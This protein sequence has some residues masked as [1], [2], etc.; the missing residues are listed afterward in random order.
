LVGAVNELPIQGTPDEP[1]SGSRVEHKR[2]VVIGDVGSLDARPCASSTVA[3]GVPATIIAART[4]PT[5]AHVVHSRKRKPFAVVG[6]GTPPKASPLL[7]RLL[8]AEVLRSLDQQFAQAHAEADNP[9]SEQA[10]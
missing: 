10:A 3:D 5:T 2:T 1:F 6:V 7:I 4:D 8:A 9:S